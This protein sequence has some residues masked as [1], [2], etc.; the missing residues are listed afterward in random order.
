METFDKAS[1]AGVVAFLQNSSPVI[2]R[3]ILDEML[4][5]QNMRQHAKTTL[6]N[7]ER[8]AE[9]AAATKVPEGAESKP[10]RDPR[11]TPRSTFGGRDTSDFLKRR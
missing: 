10:G 11:G 6:D 5:A 8:A 4:K 9:Q 3:K 1:I 2:K 7:Y